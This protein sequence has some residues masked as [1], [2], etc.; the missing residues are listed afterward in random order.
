MNKSITVGLIP[1]LIAAVIG[2]IVSQG[3][4]PFFHSE[5]PAEQYEVIQSVNAS[6]AQDQLQK[7]LNTEASKGWR[8]RSSLEINYSGNMVPCVILAK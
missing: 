2:G 5:P 8:L 4:T 7:T 3:L 6:D 1:L